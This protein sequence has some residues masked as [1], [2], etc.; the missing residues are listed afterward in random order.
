M[1]NISFELGDT[2][3]DINDPNLIKAFPLVFSKRNGLLSKY[4]YNLIPNSDGTISIDYKADK[5]FID[6]YDSSDS[7]EQFKKSLKTDVP[8]LEEQKNFSISIQENMLD[9]DNDKSQN[10]SDD[11]LAL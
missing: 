2:K 3:I 10:K 5:P 8:T 7:K 6:K 9:Y 4:N 1:Y 11:E